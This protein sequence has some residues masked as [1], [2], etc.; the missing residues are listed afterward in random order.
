MRCLRHLIPVLAL[1][2]AS[3]LVKNGDPDPAG[4]QLEARQLGG[5]ATTRND[6]VDGKC[7]SVVMVFARGTTEAGNVGQVAGPPFFDAL[8][9]KAPDLAVQGVDY[10]A[11]IGG[12][13]QGGDKAGT[14][15][16]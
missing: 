10:A 1:C 11:S 15:K 16:M 2:V 14:A 5:S 7:G 8:A 4:P 6:L 13:V 9:A 3:P 12:I